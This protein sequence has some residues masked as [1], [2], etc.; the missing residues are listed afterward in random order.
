[1]TVVA[2]L[3]THTNVSCHA[4]STLQENC[5]AAAERKLYAIAVTNHAPAMKDGA[6]IWHFSGM[7]NIPRRIDGVYL[8]RG[9][10]VNIL[11]ENGDIDI[12]EVRIKYLDY[13]IASLHEDVFKP[14]T[15][16]AHTKAFENVL[17]NPYVNTLGHLGN[18]AYPFDYERIISQCNKYNKIVEINNHSFTVREGSSKNCR[19]IALLCKQ[20][21][22]PIVLTTD[23]HISFEI[24]IC[25][26]SIAL[27]Q[28]IGYPEEL[29]LNTD[30]NR[31]RDYFLKMKG[32]DIFL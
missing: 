14:T 15:S 2:D 9:A 23:A 28:E 8:L 11:N 24:G 16:K 1:M 6:H 30:L 5:R 26:Y 17:K 32:L 22:V 7:R 25:D 3:H 27:V 13:V 31:L 12:D 4:Y 21:Q 18:G 20:Y 29:I 19:E 10:E